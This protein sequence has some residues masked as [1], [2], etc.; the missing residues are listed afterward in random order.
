MTDK[1]IDD[2]IKKLREQVSLQQDY[3]KAVDEAKKH[4]DKFYLSRD[5]INE[6]IQKKNSRGEFT[7]GKGLELAKQLG[8]TKGLNTTKSDNGELLIHDYSRTAALLDE[9]IAKKKEFSE[10]NPEGFLQQSKQIF[11]VFTRLS[12]L[13]D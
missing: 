8:I 10:T 13:Q 6:E 11:D 7:K 5:K 1:Q 4:Q 2:V 9:L 12:S 3:A